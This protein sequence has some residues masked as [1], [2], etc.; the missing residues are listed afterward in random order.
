MNLVITAMT[1]FCYSKLRNIN[2]S[3][4][5]HGGSGSVGQR[6]WARVVQVKQPAGDPVTR[7]DLMVFIRAHRTDINVQRFI[8]LFMVNIR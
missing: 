6:I 2:D 4:D 5:C 7:F 8:S 3:N 1:T